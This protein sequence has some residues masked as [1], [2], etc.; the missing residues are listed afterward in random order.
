MQE[1]PLS[2]PQFS[3]AFIICWLFK[4]DG[5]MPLMRRDASRMV[6]DCASL[7]VSDEHLSCACWPSVSFSGEVSL[8]RVCSPFDW[9]FAVV[10][11]DF[12]VV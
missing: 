3:P 4:N 12:L 10:I 5:R 2:S 6:F 9:L 7:I 1:V 8:F 11:V